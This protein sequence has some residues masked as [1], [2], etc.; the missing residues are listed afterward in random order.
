MGLGGTEPMDDEGRGETL[1][2]A[3]S[4]S[5]SICLDDVLDNGERSRAV[6][7]CGHEFHL[8]CI[9]SMF[10]SKGG[11][12]QCPN[13]RKTEKGQWL[14]ASGSHSSF[15]EF[16]L[17]DWTHDDDLYDLSYSEMPFGVHWCPFRGLTPVSSSFDGISF[18]AV[19]D[20]L[21][22][23]AV[24]AEHTAASSVARS[25]PYVAIFQPLLSSSANSNERVANGPS[26]NQQWSGLSGPNDISTSHAFPAGDLHYQIWDHHSPPFS[27][28]GSHVGATDQG[29][30]PS[31]AIRSTRGD[32]D[33]P[34]RSGSVLHPFFLDHGSGSRAGSSIM[35]SMVPPYPGVSSRS[36]DRVE[37]LHAHHHQLQFHPRTPVFS[38]VRRSSGP[39]GVPPVGPPPSSSD[40]GSNFY[41]LP[42]SGSSGRN[43]QETVNPSNSHFY[44]W[45]RDRL[46]PFPLIPVD[47]EMGWWPP[48]HQAAG[49]SDPGSRANSYWHRHG[50]ERTSSQSRPPHPPGQMHPFI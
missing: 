30:V 28:P 5:C 36:H 17:V 35:P 49:G 24:F 11:V 42:S 8:D 7:Q 38:N 15:S 9:G 46:A 10:N 14:F 19:H 6:L 44:A 31:A 4:I 34:P 47:R 43:L 50:L 22:H 2:G 26:F 45:E 3:S 32:S 48:P 25:C 33:G 39:R 27:A 23:N 20:L 18:N 1:D 21:G 41:M 37:G 12:M 29:S 16:N 13:C 40:R